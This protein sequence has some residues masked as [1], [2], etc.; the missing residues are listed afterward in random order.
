MLAKTASL[1]SEAVR[2]WV[3]DGML[4]GTTF[5]KGSFTVGSSIKDVWTYRFW[6]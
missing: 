5:L 2:K 1:V 4:I 6:S 3:S